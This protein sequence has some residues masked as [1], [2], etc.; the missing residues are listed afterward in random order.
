MYSPGVELQ[1]RAVQPGPYCYF[2]LAAMGKFKQFQHRRDTD[3]GTRGNFPASHGRSSPG[4]PQG[5]QTGLDG[6]N[7]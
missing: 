3:Q 5:N 2:V 1:R 4:M 6:T 7:F